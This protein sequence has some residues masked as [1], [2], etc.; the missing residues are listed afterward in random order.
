MFRD[1]FFKFLAAYKFFATNIY[2]EVA[3]WCTQQL[4]YLID[5]YIAYFACL[6]NRKQY[7][8]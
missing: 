7:L 5:T 1:I 3:S 2:Y 4:G 8:F 6:G